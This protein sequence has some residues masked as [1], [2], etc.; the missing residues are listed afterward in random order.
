MLHAGTPSASWEKL[1]RDYLDQIRDRLAVSD[2][3]TTAAQDTITGL[4]T[5]AERIASLSSLVRGG[6]SYTAIEFGARAIIPNPAAATL[7]NRYGDCKD[8]AVLL[9]QLLSAAAIP[10]FLCVI[11]SRGDIH[12]DFPCMAQFDH[13][14][15]ALP[16]A[17]GKTWEFIDPTNKYLEAVP[18]SAPVG[19][20]NRTALILNPAGPVLA[21]TPVYS[22]P[23]DILTKR[24]VSLR[25]DQDALLADTITIT[26]T[27]A[28]RLRAL[29]APLPP[30]DRTAAV[31]ALIGFDRLSH[32]V[33]DIRIQNIK[34]LQSPLRITIQWEARRVFHA[35]E[36]RLHLSLPT[37]VESHLIAPGS[38]DNEDDDQPLR[39]NSSIRLRSE[40]S[41]QMPPGHS[42][43]VPGGPSATAECAFGKWT[44]AVS[45]PDA[46]RTAR[47]NWD[48]A[49]KAGAFPGNQ[50]RAFTDFTH[51]SLRRLQGEWEFTPDN[52]A[53]P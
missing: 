36:G 24:D 8:Q 10:S 2:P 15:V 1:G 6:V 4:R 23:S 29:L 25:G 32:H 16:N 45:P 40:T 21:R 44:M 43:V 18:G 52:V 53:K 46:K 20:E 11:N 26:G 38:S 42:L 35:V 30:L 33:K 48:C 13:M 19:L 14:I 34:E 9:H 39:F 12:Q 37:I 49:L 5:P 28:A 7:A 17:D 3:V 41:L 22:P 51:D 27:R 31:R 50:R 47:I